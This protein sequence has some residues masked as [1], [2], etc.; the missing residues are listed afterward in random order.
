MSCV[1]N[2]IF[3]F[4]LFIGVDIVN[5]CNEVVLY[6]VCLNK[7]IVDKGNFEYVVERVIV[8][9]NELLL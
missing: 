8:G 4:F 3:I 5:I 2:L 6:V 1:W 9:N 7:K